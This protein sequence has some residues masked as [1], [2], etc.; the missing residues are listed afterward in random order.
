M[1][2]QHW[3]TN[4]LTDVPVFVEHG[5]AEAVEAEAAASLPAHRFRYPALFALNDFVEARRAMGDGMFTHF[6]PNPAAAHLMRHG[7]CGTRTE[8]GIKHEIARACSDLE[9]ALHQSLWFGRSK[10]YVR[11]KE[12]ICLLFGFVSVTRICVRPPGPGNETVNL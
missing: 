8:E 2:S 5:R 11:A 3:E 12:G 1:P 7:S 6:D 9:D 10:A 4:V